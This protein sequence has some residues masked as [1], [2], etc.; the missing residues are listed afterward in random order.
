[1]GRPLSFVSHLEPLS[2]VLLFGEYT[3]GGFGFGIG[4]DEKGGRWSECGVQDNGD[5]FG[6]RLLRLMGCD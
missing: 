4:F 6:R 1:M 2:E 5:I 3:L